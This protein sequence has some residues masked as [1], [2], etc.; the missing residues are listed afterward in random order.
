MAGRTPISNAIGYA[1]HRRRSHPVVVRVYD[2]VGNVIEMRAQT[3]A[4]TSSTRFE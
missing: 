2:G 4:S 1:M 3:N